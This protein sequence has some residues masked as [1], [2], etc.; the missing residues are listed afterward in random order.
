MAQFIP[1]ETKIKRQKIEIPYFN[2]T[3]K[4]QCE[5]PGA[6]VTYPPQY[7]KD[8]IILLMGKL[9]AG[10]VYFVEC[11]IP[12]EPPREG[13]LMMFNLNG[14]DGRVEIQ[15]LPVRGHR[16]SSYPGRSLAMALFNIANWL[17]CEVYGQ[18]FRPNSVPLIAHLIGPEG[19][20]VTEV[21]VER[22]DI[23]KLGS[24]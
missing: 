24:G 18:I 3:Q 10:G 19:K 4:G 14:V 2:D 6:A 13:Y 11:D 21:L 1:K 23:L 7:Y 22:G 16:K 17:E 9:G 15:A 8:Q 12:D 5:I 20:T